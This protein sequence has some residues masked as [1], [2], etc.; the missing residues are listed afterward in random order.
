MSSS[1][2]DL[3]LSGGL[4]ARGVLAL[5]PVQVFLLTLL[6]LDTYRL[7]RLRRVA[8]SLLVG[9]L[10]AGVAF[11]TNNLIIGVS[12]LPMLPFALLVAPLVEE[13]L[14][15]CWLEFQV[16]TRR[17]AFLV[18]ATIV[19]FAT[20]AGFATVEN[21]YY[22]RTWPE[23]PMLVWVVRGLGTAVMH[24]TAAA[25]FGI[26][27][28]GGEAA[29]RNRGVTRWLGLALAVVFHA[30]YNALLG[31]ALG[32]T[33]ALVAAAAVILA[34]AHREGERRLRAWLGRGL[35]RDRELLDLIRSGA[36]GT[37]PLG[38]YLLSLREHFGPPAVADMLCLLRLEAE[39]SIRAKGILMLREHGFRPSPEPELAARL[40]EHRWLEG[41]IG[42]AG[43]WAMAAVRPWHGHGAW[44]RRLLDAEADA[45]AD[46]AGP[47][48][49]GGAVS[50]PRPDGGGGSSTP[51]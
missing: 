46:P 7:V 10:L 17:T 31:N 14:K 51:G 49:E 20:G 47:A 18:D 29:G 2:S 25:L 15:A 30:G 32:A 23:A 26:V 38:R 42:R 5:V 1:T 44:Q 19:A 40:A 39:L 36:V 37:T 6:L 3:L 27:R 43:L 11:L 9:A 4:L 50:D 8:A 34:L 24:G 45:G 35:D 13:G 16:G 41:A 12:R 22:L 48:P 28:Q 21:L 33:A